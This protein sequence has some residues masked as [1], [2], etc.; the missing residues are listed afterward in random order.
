[1]NSAHLHLLINHVPTIGSVLGIG[2]FLLAL[3][4]RND[5]LKRASL[6]LL[7]LVALVSVPAYLSG[8]TAQAIV[9]GREGISDA[10][11]AAHQDAAVLALVFMELTGAVAWFGLWQYRRRSSPGRGTL[12][13]VL[14]LSV[15]TLAFM[16][17][18]ANVGGEIRHD[19][20]RAVQEAPGAAE[21]AGAEGGWLTA[22]GITS[23]V[24]GYAWVW[25]ASETIHFIGL[26]FLFAAVLPVN[27]RMLGFLKN[28]SVPALH[29]LLP[30]AIFGFALNTITGFLFFIAAA[31]Q[32]TQN[33]AFYWKIAFMVAAG[34]NFLYLT[35]FDEAWELKPGDESPLWA[36]VIGG[37]SIF[38]W[39]GVVLWGRLM[40]FLGLTF[41]P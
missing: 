6:E 20:I 7:F 29:R 21:A 39:F 22:A 19:E 18:A 12:T 17:R 30:W 34:A 11:I 14:A 33:P 31:D 2:L 27:L 32:Y 28:V 24:N 8:N 10:A 37:S 41:E 5:H 26:C 15:L 4:R 3:V 13:A 9:T 25:P 38:L 1:M 16:A 23:F 35:V 40:P 36:K